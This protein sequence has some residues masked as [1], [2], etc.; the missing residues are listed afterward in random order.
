M[1]KLKLNPIFK[2][3]LL[4]DLNGDGCIDEED[5]RATF[6]T[7]GE[8]NVP[9]GLVEQMLSEVCSVNFS[10]NYFHLHVHSCQA[11]NPLD[12]DAFVMLLGYKTI[13]LDP[14]DVLIEALSKWDVGQTGLISEDK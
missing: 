7:L 1:H 14:E 11:M 13:E 6:G 10:A 8:D 9:E 3:F 5:L 12:F 2:A 4:F